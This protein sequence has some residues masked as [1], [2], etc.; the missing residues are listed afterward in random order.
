[1]RVSTYAIVVAVVAGSFA[2]LAPAA[3]AV[4]VGCRRMGNNAVVGSP[5]MGLMLNWTPD[6]VVIPDGGTVTFAQADVVSHN[7]KAAGCFESPPLLVAPATISFHV[8]PDGLV[9]AD[10][11]ECDPEQT[12]FRGGKGSVGSVSGEALPVVEVDDGEVRIFYICR[13]HGPTMNGVITIVRG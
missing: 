2:A 13:V 3:H 7:A 6:C 10:G 8:S 11:R 12:D 9:S 1:M 5:P 4:D